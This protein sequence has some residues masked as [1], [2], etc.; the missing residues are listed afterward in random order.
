[1]HHDPASFETERLWLRAMR[2]DDVD[3]LLTIFADP[4]V[5]ASFG[6]GVFDRA[7]M[8][9]WVQRNLEHQQRYGYGLFSVIHKADGRL[10]GDCG[11]ENM[12]IEGVAETELGYDFRSDYWNKGLAT[13]A[14][15]SVR[16]HAFGPL[17]LRRLVSLI[18]DR[19][20]ASQRVAEK[21]GMC[22][23]ANIVRN[24]HAYCVYSLTNA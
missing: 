4:R 7:Q 2:A 5:M 8:E 15:A 17:A 11:L 23:S 13:E 18:R 14:A 24:G 22:Q 1:V 19:N 12:E 16:A 21:I 20:L 10:V 6:V 9:R 3:D